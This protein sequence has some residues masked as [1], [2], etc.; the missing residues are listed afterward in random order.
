MDQRTLL[1]ATLALMAASPAAA[2]T[3]IQTAEPAAPT[4]SPASAAT[5][6]DAV[7]TT[8]TRTRAVAGDLATPTTVV[9]REEIERRDA[10]SVLDLVRDIPGVESSGVPRTTAMQP[11]IRGLGEERIVLRL[12]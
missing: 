9:G 11:V 5:P 12:D 10:R 8:A 2:Q 7:T 6:L 4:G 3:A 1:A